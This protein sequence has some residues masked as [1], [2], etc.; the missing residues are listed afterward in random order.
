[1][2]QECIKMKHDLI[3]LTNYSGADPA[4]GANSSAARGVSGF[5]FDYG[6]MGAPVSF[7]MGI[8]TSF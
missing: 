7:N 8:R 1:M 3:L 6:N 2:K 5:G 4:V